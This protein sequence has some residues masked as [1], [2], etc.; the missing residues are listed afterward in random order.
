MECTQEQSTVICGS[1]KVSAS[2]SSFL[3]A[4]N[5]V[6]VSAFKD[7]F[8]KSVNLMMIKTEEIYIVCPKNI[9][10]IITSIL[11][12]KPIELSHSSEIRSWITQNSASWSTFTKSLTVE[13]TCAIYTETDFS[14]TYVFVAPQD[15]ELVAA[16]FKD[17][18][19][20]SQT[21]ALPEDKNTEESSCVLVYKFFLN[22]LK[23]DEEMV[24]ILQSGRPSSPGAPFI[25]I[26]GSKKSLKILKSKLENV[27]SQSC[28]LNASQAKLFTDFRDEILSDIFS[29]Y[30]VIGNVFESDLSTDSLFLTS[31]TDLISIVCS[32]TDCCPVDNY[33]GLKC[34]FSFSQAGKLLKFLQYLFDLL[35]IFEEVF[36]MNF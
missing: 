6:A 2:V 35:Y 22:F 3:E 5:D 13:Y 28:L 26:D 36:Y 14:K 16:K 15:S 1:L 30:L 9:F 27:T 7:A 29:H 23:D 18:L 11:I 19:E 21:K 10:D 17:F 20:F 25:K 33:I 8:N 4:H 34:S 32:Q 31:K 12:N 24:A